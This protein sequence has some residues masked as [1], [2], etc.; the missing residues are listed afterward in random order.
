MD[1]RK[2]SPLSPILEASQLRKR[3]GSFTAVDDISFTVLPGE[4]FGILGPNGAGKTTAIR[5]L[6]GFSPMTGGTLRIFGLDVRENLRSLK[7]RIGVCQQENNLDPDLTVFQNM[8]IFAGYFNLPRPLARERAEKLLAFIALKNRRDDKVIELS[9]GMMRRLV[10]ARALM[11]DPDLL[12]LD[13]PTTGLDP[14]SRHSVWQRLEELKKG[15]LT[16][17]LTTHYM[18]E[19]SRLCDRLI[20]MDKG[21]ILV[22]GIPVDLIRTHVGH[23]VIEV[24]E[25][26]PALLD[27]VKKKGL[28]F[29]NLGHRLLIYGDNRDA[30]FHEISSLCSHDGCIL[31]M[32]TLEDVFLKLTGRELRE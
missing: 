16:I 6:Y 23:D 15:G 22:E 18:D 1:T 4:C 24:A 17:L 28:N 25:P 7:A 19:A 10:L 5:M 3:F 14:Q 27:F 13:E 8:E 21:R 20:I 9:G 30:L 31:R 12:I 26:E 32:A 2:V 29:E 11:N